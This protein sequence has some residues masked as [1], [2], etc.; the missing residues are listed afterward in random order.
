M[1]NITNKLFGI[2]LAKVVD[3]AMVSAGGTSSEGTKRNATLISITPGVPT[4]ANPNAIK[5]T[6]T[7]HKARGFIDDYEDSQI[8]GTIVRKG[9]R[10]VTLFGASILPPVAPKTNDKVTIEGDTYDVQKIV[11]RDPAGATYELQVR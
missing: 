7:T 8:D 6:E 2:D 11:S 10:K 1:A 4:T 9:D 5:T 3:D